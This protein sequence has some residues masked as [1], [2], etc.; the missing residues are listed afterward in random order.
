LN[1]RQSETQSLHYLYNDSNISTDPDSPH[2]RQSDTSVRYRRSIASLRY[3][4]EEEPTNFEALAKEYSGNLGSRRNSITPPIDENDTIDLEAER[5]EL[6]SFLRDSMQHSTE[7][8]TPTSS[9]A[10]E[11]SLPSVPP[12]PDSPS[13]PPSSRLSPNASSGSHRRSLSVGS[14]RRTIARAAKLSNFFGTS[15]GLVWK[16]LLDDLSD[17]IREESDLEEEERAEVLEGVA[18]LRMSAGHY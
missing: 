10:S 17:V 4:I 5:V 15:R 11:F 7:I 18:R 6:R 12:L 13:T 1:R 3:L 16:V 8:P 9:N 14:H 2:S